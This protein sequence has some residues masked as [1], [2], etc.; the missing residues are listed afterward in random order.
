[1]TPSP[2]VLTASLL[3]AVALIGVPAA[4][5]AL[6]PRV[7]PEQVHPLAA[8]RSFRVRGSVRGLYPGL[9]KTIR[10]RASN[11]FAFSIELR[12]VTV[13]VRRPA[14]GCP[15]ETVRVHP[16]RGAVGISQGATRHIPLRVRMVPSAP[17]ACQGARYPLVYSGRAVRP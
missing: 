1:M 6:Q 7:D 14:P 4:I 10:A 17:D 8:A 16:W 13:T 3:L 5:V 12:R 9:A 15:A 2:K 11:P